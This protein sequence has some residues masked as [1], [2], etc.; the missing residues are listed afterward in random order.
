MQGEICLQQTFFNFPKRWEFIRGVGPGS[1]FAVSSLPGDLG[2]SQTVPGVSRCPG[3]S[4][5]FVC[6]L[7]TPATGSASWVRPWMHTDALSAA[8]NGSGL[9]CSWAGGRGQVMAARPADRRT[10]ERE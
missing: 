2:R 8:A 9:L 6:L 1:P 4:C 3:L 10:S 7:T 5:T